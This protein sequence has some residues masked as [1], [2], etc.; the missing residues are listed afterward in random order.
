M[1][2]RSTERASRAIGMGLECLGIGDRLKAVTVEVRG[3]ERQVV[4]GQGVE[5]ALVWGAVV[6]D[7]LWPLTYYQEVRSSGRD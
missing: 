3:C 1:C 6:P 7:V 2:L 5:I 4:A